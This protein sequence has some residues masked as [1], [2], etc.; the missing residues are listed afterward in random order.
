MTINEFYTTMV[1]K[2]IEAYVRLHMT[3]Q[4]NLDD[5]LTILPVVLH[6]QEARLFSYLYSKVKAYWFICGLM[7]N[8]C[9]FPVMVVEYDD[10]YMVELPEYDTNRSGSFIMCFNYLGEQV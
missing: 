5:N 10:G 1:T 9:L 4:E 6:S 3:P 7:G 8:N 2:A